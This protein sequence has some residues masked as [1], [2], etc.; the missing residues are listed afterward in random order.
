MEIVSKV[1]KGSFTIQQNQNKGYHNSEV[2]MNSRVGG[3]ASLPE[4]LSH[5]PWVSNALFCFCRP[6]TDMV[7][8][9][10]GRQSKHTHKSNKI[11]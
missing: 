8:R 3:L 1:N 5:I 6:C 10:T 2:N 7:H 11:K 4:D 9:H